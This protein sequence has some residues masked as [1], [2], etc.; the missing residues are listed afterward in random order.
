MTSTEVKAIVSPVVALDP[1]FFETSIQYIE[2]TLISCILTVDYYNDLL[3]K[4]ALLPGTPLS[5]NDQKV[6]DRV[7]NAEAYAVAFA[8]YTKDLE[9]KTNN[10]GMME[11][12]TQWSKSAAATSAKR[13]LKD[14]KQREFDYC[15]ILGNFLIDNAVDYPLFDVDAIVYEPNFR[16]FFSI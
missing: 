1:A 9:R 14:I 4:V 8:G 15:L 16:R 5:A 12:H 6:Y 7:L 11:N 13:T 10:Q 3:A 2:D